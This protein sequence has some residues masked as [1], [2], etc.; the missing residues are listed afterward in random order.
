MKVLNIIYFCWINKNKNYKN[1][2]TGQLNDIV[3]YGVLNVSKIYIE[4]CCEDIYLVDSIK[5]FIR[6]WY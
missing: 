4:V 2:I 3:S 6:T 1:I 5:D